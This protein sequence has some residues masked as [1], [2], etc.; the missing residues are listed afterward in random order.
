MSEEKWKAGDE[1]WVAHG[2][3]LTVY[4]ID[5]V[6]R[7]AVYLKRHTFYGPELIIKPLDSPDLLRTRDAAQKWLEETAEARVPRCGNCRCRRTVWSND[8]RTNLTEFNG[9]KLGP[10]C[11]RV[12]SAVRVPISYWCG[13]HEPEKPEELGADEIERRKAYEEQEAE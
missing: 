1:C 7:D 4:W 2:G 3:G 13:K 9:A 10:A 12:T 11:C 6:S 8:G 5:G